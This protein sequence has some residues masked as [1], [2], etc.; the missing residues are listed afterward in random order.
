MNKQYLP[1]FK[2]QQI[3]EQLIE[4]LA[5]EGPKRPKEI[6]ALKNYGSK[7]DQFS[8]LKELQTKDIIKRNRVSH[9]KTFYELCLDKEAKKLIVEIK[10]SYQKYMKELARAR[11]PSQADLD[12]AGQIQDLILWQIQKTLEFL[13]AIISHH[14]EN[15][16]VQQVLTNFLHRKI[17]GLME[18]LKHSKEI[19]S[20]TT[21]SVLKSTIELIEKHR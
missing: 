11:I 15:P 19:D 12:I 9:K 14:T 8:L 6:K 3:I 17:D 1:Y 7:Q 18:I 5:E 21:H 2:K 13:Q 16:S 4:E 20:K 10:N